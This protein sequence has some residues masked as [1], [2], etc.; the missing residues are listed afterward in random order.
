LDH[1]IEVNKTKSN[2]QKLGYTPSGKFYKA[3]AGEYR[4]YLGDYLSFKSIIYY[5][6]RFEYLQQGILEEIEY[7][8][9]Y[10]TVEA[11][12]LLNPYNED[13]YYFAQSV[14]TW[15]IGRVREI[16]MILEY[17][18]NFRNWDYKIPFFLGFNHFYFLKD[19]KKA[20]FY[21]KK[22]S[23]LSGAPLY[24]GL[25][26][27]FFFEGGDTAMAIN[28]IKVMIS[29]TTKDNLKKQYQVRLKA[30]E[31]IFEI[32]NAVKKFKAEKDRFPRNIEELVLLGYLKQIPKDPYG[33]NFYLDENNR[34]RTTSKLAFLNKNSE[35]EMKR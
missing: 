23:E 10:R 26:S 16:N 1:F 28:Y 35:G 31:A 22:A 14:F 19:Y 25:A 8:N 5:G 6:S 33:G 7:Y 21:F 18:S 2:I 17:V 29:T 30:L 20:A 9:L 3:V 13:I 4:W 32:E 34:V 24:V 15:D 27:R 12:V 11:S